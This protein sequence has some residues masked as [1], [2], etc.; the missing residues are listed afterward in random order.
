MGQIY[1]GALVT[2]ALV[3]FGLLRGVLWASEIRFFTD[4]AAV[5]LLYA[6]GRYSPAFC[7]MYEFMPGVSLFR[8]PADATFVFGALLAIMA[9]YLVHAW[10][11][12]KVEPRQSPG[13]AHRA[14]DCAGA[15][16][17]CGCARHS[18]RGAPSS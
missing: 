12:E 7:F 8:R 11:N 15:C 14:R 18:G 2:V 6:L 4:R 9:G 13:T 16:R 3:V 17:D 5:V 1:A 10:L